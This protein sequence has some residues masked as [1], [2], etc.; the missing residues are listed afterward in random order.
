M[1]LCQGN[2]KQ[3]ITLTIYCIKHNEDKCL[4]KAV[5]VSESTNKPN[6]TGQLTYSWV[7]ISSLKN[8]TDYTM[9]Q[10][11]LET[12]HTRH[13]LSPHEHKTS[14]AGKQ[15]RWS[16][17]HS[18]TFLIWNRYR[19]HAVFCKKSDYSGTWAD[20]VAAVMLN[21]VGLVLVLVDLVLVLM[22]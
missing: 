9:V 4:M 1:Y 15:I 2:W 11:K 5:T 22:I 16:H 13:T 12:V 17:T 10:L 6:I 19:N 7:W 18:I 3:S 20:I 21:L 8:V 14:A